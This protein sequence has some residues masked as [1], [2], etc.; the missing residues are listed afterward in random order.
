MNGPQARHLTYRVALVAG[1][2]LIALVA[3]SAGRA[4]WSVV[5]ASAHVRAQTVARSAGPDHF[6]PNLALH[7]PATAS[8]QQAEF[9]ASQAVDGDPNT[10]WNAGSW[11]PQWIEVDLGDPKA[12]DEIDL[13]VSQFPDSQ[14]THRVYGK[15]SAS[16]PY[17]LLH[18]FDGY[19]VDAQ[20]LQYV[21][22]ADQQLRYIK[23][24]TT[25]SSSWVAWREIEV[26]GP[27]NMTFLDNGSIKVGVDLNLG[28]VITHVSPSGGG[29]TD[30][31]VNEHDTGREVQQSYYSGGAGPGTPCPGYSGDWN[32][33]GAG[34][35]NGNVSTVLTH[36]NDGSTIYVKSRPLLWPL[37]N[38]P[39]DCTFE[40]WISLAGSTVQVRNRLV[41]DRSDTTSYT[42]R[43]QE[44]PAVYT[45]GR[46]GHLFTYNGRA[47]YTGGAPTEIT[48]ELPSSAMFRATEH[49]AAN[50]D[51]T[52]VGLGIVNPSVETF[53]GGFWGTRGSGGSFDDAT[54]YIAPARPEVLDWNGSYE[55][56]YALV[57]GTLDEIRAYAAAN[58]P[59]PRPD[60]HFT[61][62]RQGWWYWNASDA[63]AP[64]TG[65]L[66]VKTDLD[67]PQMFGPE[68]FWSAAD[69]PTLYIRA[70]YHTSQD[71]AELFWRAPWDDFSGERWREFGVDNDGAFHTYA[72]HLD[73][74]PGYTGTIGELRFDPVLSAEGGGTVDIAYIS[75]KPDQR[76]LSVTAD[77]H[78]S[79]TSEPA[80]ISCPG[81]C[82]APF[83]ETTDVTLRAQYAPGFAFAGWTGSCDSE[84]PACD[85]TIDGEASAAAKFVPALHRR[86]VTLYFRRGRAQGRVKVADAFTRCRGGVRVRLERRAGH[87]WKLSATGR[88]SA[89]GRYAL[90]VRTGHGT[91]RA[92]LSR[93]RLPYGHVCAAARSPLRRR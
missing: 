20:V 58:R 77:G 53:L 57:L 4:G 84:E 68:G 15:A 42:A 8:N 6:R 64:I 41:N 92:S 85:I 39:C 62:D 55:Y 34:D 24:E 73:G 7:K 10:I 29:D 87:R 21:L 52:G 60:Y 89:V 66:H 59:D 63:G 26:Y 50:V 67:D 86:S 5:G 79:V 44:L 91:Y 93:G 17:T 31:L 33:V 45:I 48:A 61:T 19:T 35:C 16:D 12:V 90:R 2:A 81:K 43:W 83:A 71:R 51:G 28:G 1:A 70:A 49:W 18:E 40:Q 74:L 23:I 14:T 56:S 38:V 30:N 9:P 54:G 75:W 13:V 65:A 72:L 22:P 32:P 76:T 82:S 36:T 69:A 37:D 88:T 80:G 47:P 78:G 3:A 46:L 11:P 27:E 25:N